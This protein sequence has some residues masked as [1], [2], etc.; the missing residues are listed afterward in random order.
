MSDRTRVLVAD[1]QTLVRSG[2]RLIL[3]AHSDLEV[4]GEANDG[5]EA[6][7]LTRDQQPHVVLMDIQM[8]RLDGIAAI[9][10]ICASPGD[11]PHILVLTTFDQDDHLYDAAR[12]G[13]TG[14]LLKTAP[15]EQ[16]V[17]AVR[18]TAAGETLLAPSITRRLLDEFTRRPP[19]G[20]IPREVSTLTDREREVLVLVARGL[21]NSEIAGEL[22]V[23]EGTVKSHL[24]RILAKLGV[25]DRVQAVVLAY[26][27]GL[28]RPGDA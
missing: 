4:V 14:F 9:A 24:N 10:R 23:S 25:R 11:A 26:E 19:G 20:G 12:A 6:V 3:E 22:V 8:P 13:A 1:D 2:I 18:A 5:V 21:S 17:A 15:P 28:V 7:Q 16:L 27:S